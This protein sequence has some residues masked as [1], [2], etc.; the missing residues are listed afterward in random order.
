MNIAHTFSYV[1]VYRMSDKWIQYLCIV[2]YV[3][4]LVNVS[5]VYNS[6]AIEIYEYFINTIDYYFDSFS[7]HNISLEISWI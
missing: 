5:A 6:I 7:E 2:A 4:I 1:R 3:G